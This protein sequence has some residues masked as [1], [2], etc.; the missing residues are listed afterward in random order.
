MRSVE[1]V[2]SC[3]MVEGEVRVPFEAVVAQGLDF[4]VSFGPRWD[5]RGTM[6]RVRKRIQA[7]VQ[8]TVGTVL[9]N[10]CQTDQLGKGDASYP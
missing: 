3:G 8:L 7:S 2:S 1:G 10:P 4:V 6:R 9:R 5:S